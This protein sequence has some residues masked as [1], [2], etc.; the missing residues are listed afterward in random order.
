MTKSG[1]ALC[2]AARASDLATVR[3]EL[4]ALPPSAPWPRDDDG[5]TALHWGAMSEHASLLPLLLSCLSASRP[6]DVRATASAQQGQTPLHWACVAGNIP[7]VRALLARGADPAATD[8]KGYSAATHAVHYGRVDLLHMLLGKCPALVAMPD[9]E[10][11]TLLQ[12]A[13]YYDHIGVVAYLLKVWNVNPDEADKSGMTPL[14]RSAQRDRPGV[15]E[16]LLRAGAGVG[17]QN[18]A[19]KTPEELVPVE[20]RTKAILRMWRKGILTTAKPIHSRHTLPKYG[21]VIF[22]WGL[23]LVSYLKYHA[24]LLRSV[25]VGIGTNVFIHVTLVLSIASH[26]TATF[27]DPGDIPQGNAEHFKEYIE[28][29]LANE[30]SEFAL[31]PSAYCFTC[32]ASRPPRS[33]HS[34]ERDRCVRLFD[35]EC[36]WVNNTVGLYTHKAL[37][38]LVVSTAFL[39]WTFIYVMINVIAKSPGVTSVFGALAESPLLCMLIMVHLCVSLFCVM[40]FFT[41]LRLVLRGQT[42][43]EHLTATRDKLTS[44]PYD[45]GWWKNLLSF[46]TSTGSGTGKSLSRFSMSTL[47][48]VILATDDGMVK[49]GPER[50]IAGKQRPADMNEEEWELSNA[51]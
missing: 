30:T 27:A 37:L 51:R 6:V 23:L 11:H 29:L 47:Q 43:Y 2:T 32:L 12:W 35:H 41:H 26:L 40:L 48:E 15:T 14:H 22:Y 17:S 1:P 3:D 49:L 5:H 25:S 39:E 46:L 13:A 45:L 42:T 16:E 28:Y 33:K 24:V 50:G 8:A 19:G 44:N 21:L 20:G 18:A 31:V 38:L 10:G 7:A 36:P 9:E 4:A 34:R